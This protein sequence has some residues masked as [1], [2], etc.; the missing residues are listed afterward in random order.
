[1]TTKK[2]NYVLPYDVSPKE[3]AIIPIAPEVVAI[4]L[5]GDDNEVEAIER[6]LEKWT[7][8][9]ETDSDAEF[10]LHIPR[11]YGFSAPEEKY[12]IDEKAQQREVTRKAIELTKSIAETKGISMKEAEEV[13][14]QLQSGDGAISFAAEFPEI[15]EQ[16][17]AMVDA[18]AISYKAE[19]IFMRRYIKDWPEHLTEYLHR[20]I[21]D[22]L[23]GFYAEEF[24][25]VEGKRLRQSQKLIENYESS[26]SIKSLIGTAVS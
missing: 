7:E 22:A 24:A 18:S 13:L 11:K 12:R 14:K 23:N 2:R 26:E 10:G 17:E 1:M 3:V 20:E 25:G 9:K 8:L 21:L 4:M 19:T 6:I 5:D 15:M 16:A